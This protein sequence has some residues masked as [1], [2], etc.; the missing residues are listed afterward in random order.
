[1]NLSAA[2]IAGD[3]IVT[4][5]S[6]NLWQNGGTLI[7]RN[8]S[9]HA[10]EDR[11]P[12]CHAVGPGCLSPW[13]RNLDINGFQYQQL[14]TLSR[15]TQQLPP[16]NAAA[17]R[18]MADRE[19]SQWRDWLE[20]QPFSPQV[21]AQ[22]GAVLKGLGRDDTATSFDMLIPVVTLRKA[23]EDLRLEGWARYY[24]YVHRIIGFA[25]A[26][27]LVAALSGLTK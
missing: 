5:T 6:S 24:F 19:L 10:F 20:R 12:K 11:S 3:L 16:G 1:V 4:T 27:F 8:A 7:L 14:G 23:D 13:P 18:D 22:L 2:K 25:L 26:S 9:A 15:N 21:Y 17:E